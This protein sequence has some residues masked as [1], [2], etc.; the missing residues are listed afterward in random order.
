M[1]EKLFQIFSTLS[2]SIRQELLRNKDCLWTHYIYLAL[3]KKLKTDIE[4]GFVSE[5]G[6]I[7]SLQ[8]R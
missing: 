6:F 4:G 2:F 5:M 8:T 7:Y 1:S 3:G